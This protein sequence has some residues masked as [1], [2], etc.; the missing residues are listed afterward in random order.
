MIFL[1][2]GSPN[3]PHLERDSEIARLRD[4]LAQSQEQCLDLINENAVI[5]AHE[6]MLVDALEIA[7]EYLPIETLIVRNEVVQADIKLVSDA[8]SASAESV[9]AWKQKIIDDALG[10]SVA[11]MYPNDLKKFEENETF[12]QAFSIEVGNG[13]ENSI[14]L[15]RKPGA[16][17]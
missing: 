11:W 7:R 13:L 17:L 5:R 16:K 9:T 8:L 3:D 12:A 6:A 1:N 15:Y 14:P 10:E 4:E 2:E